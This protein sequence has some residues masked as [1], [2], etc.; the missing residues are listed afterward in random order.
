[1]RIFRVKLVVL[2]ATFLILPS[3][4]SA[5]GLWLYEMGTP[6]SGMAAAGRAALA[7][8][9]STVAFNPAGMIRLERSELL[10]GFAGLDINAE[11]DISSATHG[12][13]D[14]G[15]AGSF[16]PVGSLAYVHKISPDLSIGIGAAS[17]FGLGLDYDDDWAG[18][19]HCQE[20]E[21]VTFGVSPAVAYRINEKFSIGAG[22]DIVYGKLYQ[23]IAVNNLL[24]RPDGQIK[25]DEDDIAFG[26]NLGILYEPI[27]GTRFGLTYRSEVELK[28]DDTVSSKGILPP[29]DRLTGKKIDLEMTIPQAVMFSIYHQ[30]T[31]KLA[32]TANL[33][34]QNQSEF[35]K[36]EFTIKDVDSTSLTIDKDYDDTWHYAIGAQYRIAEPWI[37][38]CGFAYDTSPVDD[39]TQNSPDLALDSQYR[40]ACGL[41]YDWSKDLTVGIA[42]EYLDLGEAKLE[43]SGT[44]AGDLVGKYD[45]FHVHVLSLNLAWKF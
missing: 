7:S 43:Q 20:A 18:R 26:F 14:G 10:V 6:D 42:Y 17:Y 3:L 45:P 15:N 32:L 27:T 5:A 35:G 2:A 16:V 9:A 11:F 8:D 13:G 40:Y 4:A 31:D 25:L 24:G 37:L 44:L 1:M 21:L 30:L 12:G 29:F 22:I 39:K 19:Y 23:E 41:Q 36:Q 34:W 28:F 33:G 38:S